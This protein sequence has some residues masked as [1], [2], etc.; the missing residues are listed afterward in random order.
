MIPFFR[1]IRK[2]MADDNRPIKYMRYAIGEIV[3]VVVGIL[4]ALQINNWNEE[5]KANNE[6]MEVLKR[7]RL[8]FE[9]NQRE[10]V[11]SI[12]FHKQRTD[13][14]HKLISWFEEAYDVP[15]DSFNPVIQNFME[16]WKY[17]PNKSVSN[18]AIS[19]GAISLIKNDSLT[20]KLNYWF[21]ALNKYDEVYAKLDTHRDQ[22]TFPMVE[23]YYPLRNL[24]S[25]MKP[26]FKTDLKGFFSKMENENIIVH[27]TWSADFLLNWSNHLQNVQIDIFKLIEQELAD[28]K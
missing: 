9:W 23:R 15:L 14:G 11:S 3:L 18:S 27:G 2:K 10:L 7:L 19:S 8:E 28:N 13:A 6:A 17:E 21:N 16:D 26:N 20:D 5:K 25:I 22:Y 12:R 1:K 4:I 24:D